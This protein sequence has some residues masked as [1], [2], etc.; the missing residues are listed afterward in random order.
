MLIFGKEKK[1][2]FCDLLL[3]LKKVASLFFNHDTFL[4]FFDEWKNTF[5]EFWSV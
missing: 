2:I 5:D 4:G 1:S 3:I